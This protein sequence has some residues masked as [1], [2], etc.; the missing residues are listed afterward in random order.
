MATKELQVNQLGQ[1]VD[2]SSMEMVM[3]AAG[4][5]AGAANGTKKFF[6]KKFGGIAKSKPLPAAIRKKRINF[7][8]RKLLSPKSPLMVV[9]EMV[10][11]VS[12]NF[13]DAPAGGGMAPGIPHL[14]T[15]Q[16]VVDD[17][18]F[19]GTGPSKQ[20]AKNICAEHVIQ[21]VVTK[22]CNENRNK[23]P[24]VD[25]QMA[26]PNVQP[27]VPGFGDDGTA[28]PGDGDAPKYNR[29][30]E[31]ET[32]WLQL[33]SLALFK[34]FND[35][36]AQGYVIP[37]ELLKNPNDPNN[38]TNIPQQAGQKPNQNPNPVIKP[39]PGFNQNPNP[40]IKPEPGF[41]QNLKP[42]VKPEPV[43]PKQDVQ[44]GHAPAPK[45]PKKA[46][47]IPANPTDRHPVQLLNELKGGVVFSVVGTTGVTPNIIFTM[48]CEV[49][50]QQYQGVGRNKK[51]A[52][53][54]CA[55]EA[56]KALYNIQ[57]PG[58]LNAEVTA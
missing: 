54:H 35:W 40:V 53:K 43:I 31:D 23:P 16:C 49:D 33:A 20:I 55:M 4:L 26:D 13:I 28:P 56:L 7:R 57:Y 27:S 47:E 30:I 50:G 22:K 18:T 5:A 42:W 58:T 51:D 17:Q 38:P 19:S 45:A 11:S 52:K 46:K 9:N 12:Y 21:Y 14:F 36:Q 3:G 1:D 34:L 29:Q 15:A 24:V 25:Q 48:G 10:G 32:P 8:L 2:M 37:A 39:E 44:M 41:Y 6:P